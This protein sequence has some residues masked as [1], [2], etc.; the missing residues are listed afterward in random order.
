MSVFVNNRA[1]DTLHVYWWWYNDRGDSGHV[2]PTSSGLCFRF[3]ANTWA[4]IEGDLRSGTTIVST[5]FTDAF[6]P[7]AQP[8]WTMDVDSAPSNA[9]HIAPV[10][11]AC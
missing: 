11:V 3:M 6:D 5:H 1:G 4:Q 7:A 9:V 10:S 2:A 8:N